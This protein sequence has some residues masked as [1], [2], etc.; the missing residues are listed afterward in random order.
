[1]KFR[2]KSKISRIVSLSL[3]FC[4]LNQVF[5]PSVVYALTSGPTSPEATSF[6]PV[7][8]TDMVNPLTGDFVYNLP[9]MEVPGPEGGYPL[10]LSYHGGLQPNEDASWVGLGWSLNPGA[11]NRSVNGFPDDWLGAQASRRDYWVGGFKKKTSIGVNIPIFGNVGSASFGLSFSN[12]TYAGRSWGWNAGVGIGFEGSP[13]SI[14]AGIGVNADNGDFYA[15]G[16]V[17]ATKGPFSL[18]IGISTQG[19]YANASLTASTNGKGFNVSGGLNLSTN[20][21]SLNVGIGANLS[22]ST[23]D[24][25]KSSNGPTSSLNVAGFTASVNSSKQGNIRTSTSSVSVD[26]FLVS[27]SR[28]KTRYWSDEQQESK[29]FGGLHQVTSAYEEVPNNYAYDSYSFAD[30]NLNGVDNPD[31]N[32]I[33]GGSLPSY[34]SYQVT[35]QGLGGTMRPY[36]FEGI[37]INQNRWE[38][39]N[40]TTNVQTVKYYSNFYGDYPE[41]RFDND[42]SNNYLQ[43][44][45][46]YP[47]VNNEIYIWDPPFSGPTPI[48]ADWYNGGGSSNLLAGSRDINY[49]V[50]T[51][52]GTVHNYDNKFITPVV[53]GLNRRAHTY[54]SELSNHIAGFSITN[55]NGITYHYNLP[56]YA[57]DEEMYQENTA[58][59]PGEM[60]NRQRKRE[61]YAY[62]WHLTAITGPDYVDRGT[63]GQVDASDYGYWV[64]FEYGK[65]SDQ[66][67][68]RNPSEGYQTDDDSQFRTVGMGKREIYYLNAVRTRSHVAIF[69]KDIRKDAKGASS[70]IF[71]TNSDK[72]Y[73]NDGLYNIN[74]TISMRLD[75]I[76]LLNASDASFVT[77]S[78]G[79]NNYITNGRTVTCT[80]CELENNILDRYDVGVVGRAN[81]EAKAIRIID[82]NYDYSLAK[83][84][85]NSFEM[86]ST[87]TKEGKLTL[88]SVK[89]RGKGGVSLLPSTD[90]EYELDPSESKSFTGTLSSNSF[91]GSSTAFNVGDL[92]ANASTGAFYGVI[93]AKGSPTGGNST[94]TLKN[95]T[96][97]GGAITATLK[98]TKNPPYNKEFYD[99]W[100]MYKAD[101]SYT[102]NSNLDR[103]T[104]P[105]SN[106][107]S[108][109][110]SLR[111]VITGLGAEVKIKYEGD[112]YSKSVLNESR[113][114]QI[115]NFTNVGG[116]DY[117]FN[118]TNS[119]IPNLNELF[120]IGDNISLITMMWSTPGYSPLNSDDYPA[121]VVTAV[122]GN[123]LSIRVSP[124]HHQGL[125]GHTSFIAGN[126]GF[127]AMTRKFGGGVRVKSLVIDDLFGVRASTNYNYNQINNGIDSQISSGVTS[128]EPVSVDKTS[129]LPSGSENSYRITL[130]RDMNRLLSLSREVPGPGVMYE[131]V[132]V[133][134]EVF[135]NAGI[136]NGKIAGSKTMEFEVFRD[137]MIGKQDV[138]APRSALR[139]PGANYYTRN[140]VLK[141]LVSG[142][143]SLKRVISYDDK[144]QKINETINHYL[145]DGLEH[146]KHADFMKAY[147][148]R[149]VNYKKQGLLKE[150]YAEAKSVWTGSGEN[151]HVKATLTARENFPNVQTG[152]TVI[153]YV[154]DVRR[155]T[156]NEEFDFYSG[157]GVKTVTTDSYGNRYM[158]ETI[159]AYKKYTEMGLKTFG[160]T[161]KHMLAQETASYRYKVDAANQKLGLIGAN[162]STWAVDV[163]VLDPVGTAIVQNNASTNGKIWRKKEIYSW[164]PA[165]QSANGITPMG[166][167]TAFDWTT[168]GSS[169]VGWLKISENT[170]FDVYSK[171][172]EDKN[173]N[174]L[175]SAMRMGFNNTKI[176]ATSSPASY[177]EMAYSGAE[178]S[179]SGSGMTVGDGSISSSFAH[180][181]MKSIAL[182]SNGGQIFK[183]TAPLSKLDPVRRD[184]FISAWVTGANI[185]QIGKARLYYS[186]DG[187]SPVYGGTTLQKV[188][189]GWY[190]IEMQIPASIITTGVTSL[191]VG[192]SNLTGGGTLYFDDFRFQPFNAGM[193][194]YVYDAFSGELTYILDN[195]NLYV[196]YEYDAAGRLIKVYRETLG[197]TVVPKVKEMQY[198]YRRT[199]L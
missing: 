154:T 7:D 26:L 103:L 102:N 9:L 87:G 182:P 69:E 150:R 94:Y 167:V 191:S 163:P 192:C 22:Y 146:L 157:A 17:G 115:S 194:S 140:L 121:P 116:Y 25:S 113:P 181:G 48:D 29:I 71:N 195:N 162:V 111:K 51:P 83:A 173:M 193:V 101:Y 5:T 52:T 178:D 164:M 133:E 175:Y 79:S 198:N 63:I 107:S 10:T 68:W 128:Y 160:G 143:G 100:G 75:K 88:K 187:G 31:P 105:V 62:T 27:Y 186:I 32:K 46:D 189:A 148:N 86:Y 152:Q 177:Y 59:S 18:A 118:I 176:V 151:Y 14:G 65:W 58:Y 97:S 1:M 38:M 169:G 135:D 99:L 96:Y 174:N 30:E 34:D 153:D 110:W 188:A 137:N 24:I 132:N 172:L 47:N 20:F 74:S 129:S 73:N 66:Y 199:N 61:G 13:F 197:K 15:Y 54:Q 109:V 131:N 76:Y 138:T 40:P 119:N 53:Y 179:M 28:E 90:F 149:L 60:F 67:C 11:I 16:Q 72:D 155:S 130:Y 2:Y 114:F 106:M 70:E 8:T 82:M 57:Y 190:L 108:D 158:D 21:Q 41:F 19:P 165:G 123:Q 77:T 98:T 3:L 6:E 23:Q 50:T 33:Q 78:S 112:T 55:S 85:T 147:E 45:G 171:P 91:I 185:T 159:P 126:V 156:V 122:S 95:S 117:Q 39:V 184:Y 37:T 141:K 64:S 56:A 84:T 136:S 183:Y 104:T 4:F 36:A 92:L 161:N 35:A 43:S 49:Y 124:A 170:L 80:G 134:T 139:Y 142:I 180:T 144:G 42:F 125:T 89:F 12:D 81:L 166:S 127:S 196:K 145:S 44:Y 168:P 120:R 93:I